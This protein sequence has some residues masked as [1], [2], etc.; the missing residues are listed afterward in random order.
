[1]VRLQSSELNAINAAKERERRAALA[2][3]GAASPVAAGKAAPLVRAPTLAAKNQSI[4]AKPQDPYVLA[5]AAL[6]VSGGE[7]VQDPHTLP[8]STAGAAG[9][10][11]PVLPVC[12]PFLP[13]SLAPS[14]AAT[15]PGAGIAAPGASKEAVAAAAAL[16]SFSPTPQQQLFAGLLE[17][18]DAAASAF[19]FE[20]DAIPFPELLLQV[21]KTLQS[22]GRGVLTASSAPGAVPSL[23]SLDA[24]RCKAQ[25]YSSSTGPLTG[26]SSAENGTSRPASRMTGKS[27]STLPTDR[28]AT[29]SAV[30]A[31]TVVTAADG[32][33]TEIT[34]TPEPTPE[35]EPVA[36]DMLNHT[37]V[38]VSV[39][40]DLA[41]TRFDLDEPAVLLEPEGDDFVLGITSQEKPI[42]D[43]NASMSESATAKLGASMASTT[44]STSSQLKVAASAGT[45]APIVSPLPLLKLPM[46]TQSFFSQTMSLGSRVFSFRKWLCDSWVAV[47]PAA[48]PGGLSE[49]TVPPQDLPDSNDPPLSSIVSCAA[50]VYLDLLQPLHPA[51][52]GVPTVLFAMVEAVAVASA[53]CGE[54]LPIVEQVAP[55]QTPEISAR[56]EQLELV[57][58]SGYQ[59][60]VV[61]HAIGNDDDTGSEA[62]G[63][64]SSHDQFAFEHLLELH[65]NTAELTPPQE[66][67]ATS[68]TLYAAARARR[69]ALPVNVPVCPSPLMLTA[70][71]MMGGVSVTLH[72]DHSDSAF[73]GSSKG[74]DGNI[75]GWDTTTAN[76]SAA[77]KSATGFGVNA[78]AG[79]SVAEL[80]AR[81]LV[82]PSE[83]RSRPALYERSH[84]I[85]VL[86]LQDV[87]EMY[88][89][90][91]AAAMRWFQEK[92]AV[93][94]ISGNR[95]GPGSAVGDASEVNH[96]A[97]AD[98]D[99][100]DTEFISID[101]CDFAMLRV[102]AGA[103]EAGMLRI[104]DLLMGVPA[105]TRGHSLQGTSKIVNNGS[106]VVPDSILS[107][108]VDVYRPV[109]LLVADRISLY[110]LLPFPMV[111]PIGCM[112]FQK[113]RV[114]RQRDMPD[115][116]IPQATHGPWTRGDLDQAATT[117]RQLGAIPV[118]FLSP[119]DV[120]VR[121]HERDDEKDVDH[122]G[123]EG[124]S[125][126]TSTTLT[127][128]QRPAQR[129]SNETELSCFLSEIEG[130]IELYG[131]D[132]SSVANASGIIA[133]AARR[134]F[135]LRAAERLLQRVELLSF[136][137][138]LG[139]LENRAITVADASEC[140]RQ[141]L[142]ALESS[143]SD[144]KVSNSRPGTAATEATENKTGR[145]S[146]RGSRPNTRQ[147]SREKDRPPSP[148]FS[149]QLA[150]SDVNVK[151]R[152]VE[153]NEAQWRREIPYLDSVTFGQAV[154][155][156]VLSSGCIAGGR[157]APD[158]CLFTAYDGASDVQILAVHTST[159]QR[160]VE[161]VDLSGFELLSSKTGN[162]SSTTAVVD[163][164]SNLQFSK[165]SVSAAPEGVLR[166]SFRQWLDDAVA[167][168]ENKD[169]SWLL[170]LGLP[171]PPPED[172][173]GRAS[174]Q[175]QQH[176]ESQISHNDKDD[177][178]LS[179]FPIYRMYPASEGVVTAE[180]CYPQYL[181]AALGLNEA[182][183]SQKRPPHCVTV[184]SHG[185]TFGLRPITA[186]HA[187]HLFQAVFDCSPV[188][189]A[190]PASLLPGPSQVT[191]QALPRTS[192]KADGLGSIA[193]T[194]VASTGL[195][196]QMTSD[197]SVSEQFVRAMK[198]PAADGQ[199]VKSPFW[200]A[201]LHEAGRTHRLSDGAIIRH[202]QTAAGS[203]V[204]H[205]LFPDGKAEWMAAPGDC[206]NLLLPLLRNFLD[207]Y[208]ISS[209]VTEDESVESDNESRFSE[210][211]DS[212][213]GDRS[214]DSDANV[215][216]SQR[217]VDVLATVASVLFR[218]NGVTGEATATVTCTEDGRLRTYGED[219]VPLH[220]AVLHM[221]AVPVYS[222]VD[223]ATCALVSVRYGFCPVPDPLHESTVVAA[224]AEFVANQA[225]YEAQVAL[226][227][228]GRD[229]L[230]AVRAAQ[231]SDAERARERLR[232]LGGVW[233]GVCTDPAVDPTRP[234]HDMLGTGPQKGR[235]VIVHYKGGGNLCLHADG[236]GIFTDEKSGRRVTTKASYATLEVDMNYDL[237]A[238]LH[239]AGS[240]KLGTTSA[241]LS[242]G[243]RTR[244]VLTLPD[245]V[246]ISADY[247][248]AVTA[249]VNG[250]IRVHR[251]DNGV[252]VA[253]DDG[254]VQY[255][256]PNAQQRTPNSAGEAGSVRTPRSAIAVANGRPE[257]PL[258]H[259]SDILDSA[260]A[261][262][263]SK[264][265]CPLSPLGCYEFNLRKGTFSTTDFQ[266]N[267]FEVSSEGVLDVDIPGILFD[268]TDD[269]PRQQEK[270]TFH[271]V[272]PFR[273]AG[274]HEMAPL[275][276]QQAAESAARAVA[277]PRRP[278]PGSLA[279][280]KSSLVLKASA[281]GT[282][283]EIASIAS[284]AGSIPVS[285]VYP[286]VSR[287]REPAVFLLEA[288]SGRAAQLLSS[289]AWSSLEQ[290]SHSQL[291]DAGPSKGTS[292]S[293]GRPALTLND[294]A[295]IGA[296]G[297]NG[298]STQ[299][300]SR[301][302]AVHNA[303]DQLL[304]GKIPSRAAND[305]HGLCPSPKR[306]GRLELR[307]CSGPFWVVPPSPKEPRYN[308]E[309]VFGASS[310]L[311]PQ[312][313]QRR[314]RH[315]VLQTEFADSQGAGDIDSDDDG[316]DGSGSP[317]S[318]SRGLSLAMRRRAARFLVICRLPELVN[319]P[320]PSVKIPGSRLSPPPLRGHQLFTLRTEILQYLLLTSRFVS[321][322]QEAATKVFMLRQAISK[323]IK[324]FPVRDMRPATT[325]KAESDLAMRILGLRDQN[326]AVE[327]KRRAEQRAN[328]LRTEQ[329][330]RAA[331]ALVD[332]ARKTRNA[333]M[334]S[335]VQTL[336]S[337]GDFKQPGT[338]ELL[339]SPSKLIA[340]VGGGT[341]RIIAEGAGSLQP[342]V[343]AAVTDASAAMGGMEELVNAQLDEDDERRI[344]REEAPKQQPESSDT[345]GAKV[346]VRT[347][348]S[349]R[350]DL[351]PSPE[352]DARREILATGAATISAERLQA[353][354]KARALETLRLQSRLGPDAPIPDGPI[355]RQT[356]F[357][358]AH[359][360][361]EWTFT[362][363]DPLTIP[364]SVAN[365][366]STLQHSLGSQSVPREFTGALEDPR[367]LGAAAPPRPRSN[368]QGSMQNP[369]GLGYASAGYGAY[370]SPQELVGIPQRRPSFSREGSLSN[371]LQGA[372]RASLALN[373]SGS[374]AGSIPVMYP[375]SQADSR[376]GALASQPAQQQSAGALAG[377][378]L[379]PRRKR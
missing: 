166:P 252:L 98:A 260:A 52:V 379:P 216:V 26:A 364:G 221:N 334:R 328:A 137:A 75:W 362:P 323:R 96:G 20:R 61:A 209:V 1:V 157:S 290:R 89:I 343:D 337:R 46:L 113:S 30:Q 17:I 265:L 318:S 227:R 140:W 280:A 373:T 349:P 188:I 310:R 11:E 223:A 222:G 59:P 206:R 23:T 67:K 149:K 371:V 41:L 7:N 247:D 215:Q 74:S 202:L 336:A 192:K 116:E 44:L 287:A 325:R 370:P 297:A 214:T 66:P 269:N 308:V 235:T 241:A 194:Y 259:H 167:R 212:S 199:P 187:T 210:G 224:E 342:T 119:V 13:L 302:L 184:E 78:S 230:V 341:V 138:S 50:G 324:E 367:G 122:D 39:M 169:E 226:Y 77:G 196:V 162:G 353:I 111:D 93:S 82:P 244:A 143:A 335:L 283:T 114:A 314:V 168:T 72:P 6:A 208:E 365:V 270:N 378:A 233:S 107:L 126:E 22:S 305:R 253:L 340:A 288:S 165:N 363:M 32:T 218:V 306:G 25:G 135:R 229:L 21:R 346:D 171:P 307:V 51:C 200:P 289:K 183:G 94:V 45:A 79:L 348:E 106:I 5:E 189:P 263:S 175:D 100:G 369:S 366:G 125:R 132:K 225:T 58:P 321:A 347:A 4:A 204:Q 220:G 257:D 251:P 130:D 255:R 191:V 271:L 319:P 267:T 173:E 154:L 311:S 87:I 80:A 249:M 276:A 295:D 127:L 246:V 144:V 85:E 101:S 213:W 49:L 43:G 317:T 301:Y 322:V 14:I 86:P 15:V 262:Q 115:N 131:L 146:S 351:P 377:L 238:R 315:D 84:R 284:A 293:N 236:T 338:L 203:H 54:I 64:A 277:S 120:V 352:V 110:S 329:E 197:G 104:S 158:S 331:H 36:N 198:G 320:P 123:N 60:A 375:D 141:S 180:N 358:Q 71:D 70:R 266:H 136:A 128:R 99:R 355:G 248:T 47:L 274:M 304:P 326:L 309:A 219:Q 55:D 232:L 90:K 103:A 18:V 148:G 177:K 299:L 156:S 159:P 33:T 312:A 344:A 316:G 376:R 172:I 134:L 63:G 145:P 38:A 102:A 153:G 31:V 57:L 105:A 124:K 83:L 237:V 73:T 48:V 254:L 117:L 330:E 186:S 242:I 345:V 296:T 69:R 181:R 155:N 161:R 359:G 282:G 151:R 118:A 264:G 205:T 357:A 291:R 217:V 56:S 234:I 9:G 2:A 142:L 92:S 42:V 360:A 292:T 201:W 150:L 228:K 231:E 339:T 261:H 174:K 88:N 313:K 19:S 207:E 286:A 3:A 170:D 182:A 275:R 374:S 368:P 37:L 34:A 356:N 28:P 179:E 372:A 27:L 112:T 164:G 361:N 273:T 152:A 121:A 160:R 35:R 10:F 185:A 278:V 97:D 211:R 65:L 129:G 300:L 16:A 279:S 239:T 40:R 147:T 294:A 8:T 243:P 62:S 193:L 29:S 281:T 163:I 245:E 76:G 250:R 190:L 333:A 12:L 53:L 303:L 176:P 24:F 256:P 195:T 272:P 139:V 258:L 298:A 91:Q 332:A 178:E 133:A 327:A 95:F 354:E 268:K 350:K 240:R 109:P 108:D 68:A 81:H 285:V